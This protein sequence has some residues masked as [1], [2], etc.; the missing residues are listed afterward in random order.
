MT[1]QQA[2]AGGPSM[3]VVQYGVQFAVL[4]AKSPSV[5]ASTGAC[6]CGHTAFK[7]HT[8]H[9]LTASAVTSAILP[10]SSCSRVHSDALFIKVHYL[11]HMRSCFVSMHSTL[12]GKP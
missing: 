9:A 3:Q 10:T 8:P 12:H 2:R 1:H 7:G 4:I 6:C 5:H 11:S